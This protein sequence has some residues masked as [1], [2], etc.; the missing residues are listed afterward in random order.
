M[1]RTRAN[2]NHGLS[3][4]KLY[5]VWNAMNDR[6]HNEN[7]IVY[8]RYGARGIF[9]CDEWR[10]GNSSNYFAFREWCLANGWKPGLTIDRVDNDAGYSP[11]NCRVVCNRTQARNR[12]STIWIQV[13]EDTKLSLPAACEKFGVNYKNCREF[14]YRRRDAMSPS[15]AYFKYIKG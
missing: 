6:C 3:N 5:Y 13:D 7:A 12:R 11:D 2:G 14:M 8:H 9:V 10:T 1:N 4:E 15:E